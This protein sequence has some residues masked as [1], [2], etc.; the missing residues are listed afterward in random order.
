[1]ERRVKKSLAGLIVAVGA[2]AVA[3]PSYAATNAGDMSVGLAQPIPTA[4]AGSQSGLAQ[5]GI[6][7]VQYYG[8]PYHHWHHPYYRHSY[9]HHY[10]RHHGVRIGPVV[11][12]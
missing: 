7:M 10:Y 9:Y 5:P 6:T 2:F 1:M 12:R 4:I 8:R 3:A 11:I